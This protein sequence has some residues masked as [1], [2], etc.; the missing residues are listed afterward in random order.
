MNRFHLDEVQAQ[1]ICDMRL[2]ALQGLNREKLQEEYN[3]LEKKIA[4]YQELLSNR[5]KLVGVMKQE[6]LE[7]RDK[8]GD[9]RMTEIQDVEDEIDIEDLIEEETC[10]FTLTAAG[11][12]V[13]EEDDDIL[14]ISD[15]GTIIRMAAADVNLYSR[16]AQGVRVMRVSEGTKV[17]SLARVPQENEGETQ[18]ET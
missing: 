12:K 6:L 17:I 15:D 5:E 11:V 9:D 3:E 2:I 18:E 1:A 8:Y 4:W 14:L 7:I 13:V 16:T 10:V